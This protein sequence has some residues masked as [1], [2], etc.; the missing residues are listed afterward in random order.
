MNEDTS[1]FTHSGTSH[2]FGASIWRPIAGNIVRFTLEYSDSVATDDIFS[3]GAVMPGFAYNN[4]SYVDG[5]RYRGRTLGFSLD[6]DSRLLSLQMAFN[7]DG[8]RFYQLSLH[9]AQISD[10]QNQ[11]GNAVTSAPVTVNLA[12]ARLTMPLPGLRLDLALRLQD[13]QPRPARGFAA[14]LETAVHFAL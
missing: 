5:M 8:G 7:D 2:L 9:H 6:S 14:A 10:A 13:D 11:L 12:E 3:F 1:P 4:F